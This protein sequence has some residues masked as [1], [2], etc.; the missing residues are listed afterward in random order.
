MGRNDSRAVFETFATKDLRQYGTM[1][2]YI[3]AETDPNQAPLQDKDLTAVIRIGPDFV[4]N[5]YEVR[6]PLYMTPLSAASLNPDTDAYNDTLWRAIN[7]L[8]S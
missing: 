2:M 4:N 8:K 6:I 7:S 5:Y 3:H 1:Q